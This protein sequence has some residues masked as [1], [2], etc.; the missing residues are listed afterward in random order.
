[1][2]K[3][4]VKVKWV[5]KGLLDKSNPLT[6]TQ[7]TD[8]IMELI[9]DEPKLIAEETKIK[10]KENSRLVRVALIMGICIGVVIGVFIMMAFF[11][12]LR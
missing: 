5:L 9:G 8:K 4:R 10:D 12:I 3:L 7:A 2:D 11:F 6:I 1:M